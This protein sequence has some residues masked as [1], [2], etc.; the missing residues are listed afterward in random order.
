MRSVWLDLPPGGQ[1][2]MNAALN[3]IQ[4]FTIQA[5]HIQKQVSS[6]FQPLFSHFNAVEISN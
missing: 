4:P 5:V 3:Q 2:L 1:K 6:N